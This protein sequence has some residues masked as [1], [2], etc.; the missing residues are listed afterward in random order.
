MQSLE[1]VDLEWLCALA[2]LFLASSAASIWKKRK[3]GLV[4]IEFDHVEFFNFWYCN[5]KMMQKK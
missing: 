3:G 5:L 4:Q 1:G 2:K